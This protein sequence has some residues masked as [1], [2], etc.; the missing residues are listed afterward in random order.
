MTHTILELNKT[1]YYQI[2]Q[3]ADLVWPWRIQRH[4]W[5]RFTINHTGFSSNQSLSMRFWNSVEPM[6]T[7]ITGLPNCNQ[8]WFSANKN[9]RELGHWDISSTAPKTQ[10]LVWLTPV[11][12]DVEFYLCV[13][14]MENKLN[15]FYLGVDLLGTL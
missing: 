6:G 5:I 12:H 4:Q 11:P 7:S 9:A 10:D 14:N 3:G 1:G 8:R 2:D 13:R 15:S